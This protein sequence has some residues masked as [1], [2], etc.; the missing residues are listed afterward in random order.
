MVNDPTRTPQAT[1]QMGYY[2]T[3][4]YFWGLSLAVMRTT[5]SN[6]RNAQP[7]RSRISVVL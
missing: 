4:S 2:D 5:Y 1:T 3:P 7:V 6:Q